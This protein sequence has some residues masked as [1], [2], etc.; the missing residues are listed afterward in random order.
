MKKNF[1][2]LHTHSHYSLL[3][4][5]GKIPDIVGKAKK[6]GMEAIGLTDH[7]NLYGAIEFY[8]TCIDEGIK[9]IIGMEGYIAPNKR[10]QKRAR[11]DANPYH[12][13][14]LAVTNEGYKNLIKISS[15]AFTKGYYYKPR[16]DYEF[17]REHSK[18]IIALSGCV[19]GHIPR[20]LISGNMDTAKEIITMYK[21]IF[22]EENFFFEIQDFEA[23]DKQVVT[24]KALIELS[25]EMSVP[26]IATNDTHYV[27]KEDSD[28]HDVLLCIQT[29][30]TVDDT[31]RMDLRDTDLSFRSRE[32]MEAAFAHVPQ[33]LD[34]TMEIAKR[35]NI[36]IELGKTHLPSYVIPKEQTYDDVLEDMCLDRFQ[37]KY[38]FTLQNL[39]KETLDNITD[40][41]QKTRAIRL[42]FELSTIKRMGFSSYFLI[43]QDFVNWAK[44]Q[45]MLVGPGRG[46]AAG[47]IVSYLLGITSLDPIDYG[48]LFERFL[49]PDRISMPDIDIDFPDDRRDEVIKYVEQKYGKDHVAQII[50]F[51]TMAARAAVRD[52]GR[53]LGY[54]YVFCDKLAKAIPMFTSLD[55]ALE[56]VQ[57]FK[58]IYEDDPDAKRVIDSARKLEGVCRHAS[59]HACGI[60]ITNK[61]LDEYL[62][63]QYVNNDDSALVSQ[64]SLHPVE[65]LGLLK[66]DFL[67][68][69]NLTII[70]NAQ[71]IIKKTHNIDI[72]PENPP[73]DD[74]KTFELFQRGDTVGVFQFESAGMQR[75]MKQLQPNQLSDIIAMVALYR[76]GPMDFIP[77]FINGKHGRKQITYLHPKLEPI[78]AETY[79]VAVF[80]EQV[81][82]IS[83]EIAGFTPGEADTLR[84][85][86]GKKIKELMDEQKKK[87]IDGCVAN[88]IDNTTSVKLWEQIE[89]F[90]QYGFNRSHAACYGYIGYITA[91][92]KANFPAEYMAALLTADKENSDRVT[93]ETEECKKMNID[94]LPPNVNESFAD[95]TVVA[96]PEDTSRKA[97]RFGLGAIKNV[98]ANIINVIVDERDTNGAFA[99]IDDFV[100]RVHTKDLNKKSF[101]SLA[102]CGALDAFEERG[103]LLG[104]ME[105]ILRHAKEL[106][107]AK[108][109]GQESLFGDNAG[110]T[111]APALRLKPAAESTRTEKL[112]WEKELLGLYVSEH[113]MAIFQEPLK[114]I[115]SPCRTLGEFPEQGKARVAGVITK[116]HA[117]LTKKGDKMAFVT[118]EDLSGGVELLVFPKALEKY[119]EM[120]AEGI[121]IIADGK[122]SHKDEVAKLLVDNIRILTDENKND[123][124]KL[125]PLSTSNRNH[126]FPRQPFPQPQPRQEQ[127]QPVQQPNRQL[128]ENLGKDSILLYFQNQVQQKDLQGLKDILEQ[129]S[130]GN[131]M[132]YIAIPIEGSHKR[133]KT[134]YK[135]DMSQEIMTQIKAELGDE[136]VILSV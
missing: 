71:R 126:T 57:E 14:M 82:Q 43:V 32:E 77:D 67:G 85:A 99:T 84:K 97:I 87:F 111:A 26:L 64:F 117:I 75:Y 124:V 83:R 4:G 58:Q 93:I 42:E 27:N 17:L 44:D 74:V 66:M 132:V 120:I 15:D 88:G 79:G 6:L 12:I 121:T 110:E 63:Y 33:A 60:V 65:D 130:A 105:D 59:I 25:K 51:G 98:G 36:E 48:L 9:P 46:S 16:T 68:L 54:P 55:K 109:S 78:L 119:S 116:I 127:P 133:I 136:S 115:V 91:Y 3:D 114:Q 135:I 62:P 112:T 38:A 90:A 69:K 73:L 113:P 11:I 118:I 2:H 5:L 104:N 1:T 31:N 86:M 22:G 39:S 101:E 107:K 52:A 131:H 81:M 8:Q 45:G 108:E 100:T 129:A 125:K 19:N 28:A 24:N 96:N 53:A 70:Q 50:T 128:M 102:K 13:T 89:P 7:G 49:N 10:T 95:F 56:K 30:K 34:N 35:A 41:Q 29:N 20:E 72:D 61:P 92:L 122:V 123:M 80:Q 76:P 94:V 106:H 23:L 103:R 18:G 134:P 40:E 37:K 21:E 47:S